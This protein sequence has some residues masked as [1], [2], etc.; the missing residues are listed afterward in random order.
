MRAF[1]GEVIS[2]SAPPSF[3]R[4]LRLPLL[5]VTPSVAEGST[6]DIAKQYKKSYFGNS[7]NYIFSKVKPHGNNSVGNKFSLVI[8]RLRSISRKSY[9]NK[10]HISFNANLSRTRRTKEGIAK[11]EALAVDFSLAL[12]AGQRKKGN[13]VNIKLQFCKV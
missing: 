11:R 3:H 5:P 12:D 7:D 13:F 4:S 6:A 2:L 1:H 8:L 9:G 10:L